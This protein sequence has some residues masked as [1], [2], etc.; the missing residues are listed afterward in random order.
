M[1]IATHVRVPTDVFFF[2]G[3]VIVSCQ[4]LSLKWKKPNQLCWGTNCNFFLFF[5]YVEELRNRNLLYYCFTSVWT[6]L[7]SFVVICFVVF[8]SIIWLWLPLN[9]DLFYKQANEGNETVFKWL[10]E[11]TKTETSLTLKFLAYPE[12]RENPA[13]N[14]VYLCILWKANPFRVSPRATLL[15]T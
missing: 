12:Q 14:C 2:S 3:C 6:G 5:V 1:Y 4:R 8:V 9:C 13:A 11:Q 7:S 10:P 15:F